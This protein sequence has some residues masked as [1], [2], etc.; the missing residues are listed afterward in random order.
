MV[1][2]Q[3]GSCEERKQPCGECEIRLETRLRRDDCEG[4]RLQVSQHM[5]FFFKHHTSSCWELAGSTN[6]EAET[7]PLNTRVQPNQNKMSNSLGKTVHPRV[8]IVFKRSASLLEEG[9]ASYAFYF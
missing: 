8:E 9:N 7:V 4:G 1:L 3:R 2:M 6:L 5:L